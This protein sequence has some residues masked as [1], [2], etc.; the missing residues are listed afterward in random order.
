MKLVEDAIGNLNDG[1]EAWAA[2]LEAK[3]GPLRSAVEEQEAAES[4]SQA[5]LSS[6]L[7][8]LEARLSEARVV[9]EGQSREGVIRHLET[10]MGRKTKVRQQT[11]V[12][13]S[14]FRRGRFQ[15]P[16]P[17]GPPPPRALPRPFAPR[18]PRPRPLLPWPSFWYLLAWSVDWSARSSNRRH[19]CASSV[20]RVLASVIT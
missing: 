5:A 3:L 13:V 18:P 20:R 11:V 4:A 1:K 17:P 15:P 10:V 12:R 7:S 9:E 14:D 16:P 19:V 6:K 8:L 2:L